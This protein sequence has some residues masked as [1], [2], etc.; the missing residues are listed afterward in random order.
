VGTIFE[1]YNSTD[2][3][4]AGGG[5]EYEVVEGFGW[6]NGVLLWAADVF[7]QQLTTPRC[8]NIS[9]AD[10]EPGSEKKSSALLVDKR[11]S[12]WLKKTKGKGKSQ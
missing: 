6:S 1:K 9:A 10:V 3:N 12:H 2:I 7:G 4:A 11:D 5:G 8:G